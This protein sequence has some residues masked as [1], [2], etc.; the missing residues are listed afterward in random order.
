MPV[1]SGWPLTAE[2][3]RFFVPKFVLEELAQD[4]LSSDLYPHGMGYYPHALGHK[5]ERDAHEDHLMMYCTGGSGTLSVGTQ[6]IPISKGDLV[7]LP[8]GVAHF[9]EA[10][11]QDPWSIYWV[12][13]DGEHSDL[14]I[15]QL[16]LS[17]DRYSLHIGI[18]PKLVSDFQLLLGTRQT[19]YS[20]SVFIHAANHLKQLLTYITVLIP[21]SLPQSGQFID[22]NI[23]HAL[24]QEHL[25]GKL[26]LE[27]IAASVNLS[28][29]HFSKKYKE[30]TGNSPIQHFI[31]LKMEEACYLMDI[32]EKNM[33][34]IS[35]ALGYEDTHYFSRLFKKVIG[36]SPRDYRKLK[37][38]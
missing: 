31:H 34:E 33:T 24:M 13:F 38:G 22:L 19:G 10:D 37:R 18:H 12:H 29:Y 25:Y 36:L 32:S 26:D 7:I 14:F 3:I 30:L 1:S 21:Q 11:S 4:A 9:Y 28:K 23:V 27:T 5:M 20:K 6:Q 2:G 8:K 35:D 17:P 15:E 16:G